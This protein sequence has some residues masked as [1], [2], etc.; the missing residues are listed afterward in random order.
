MPGLYSV[1]D[2]G[3]KGDGATKDT[4]AIQAAIEACARSGGGRVYFPNG[5]FLSGTI[6]LRDNVTLSLDASAVLVGS[7]EAGD[8]SAKPFPARDLDVGGF[9]IWALIYADGAKNIG[10]E[11]PG[12]IDGNGKGFPPV[13]HA[14]DT[15][16]S[17]RARAIFLGSSPIIVGSRWKW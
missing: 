7:P 15:A 11:G 4:A 8:Y 17:L 5:K 14:P 13:K 16:G 6:T 1:R 10:I 3:A 9:E 12:L 2:F